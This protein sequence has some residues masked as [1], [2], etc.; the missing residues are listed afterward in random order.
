MK[1]H[2]KHLTEKPSQGIYLPIFVSPT[3]ASSCVDGR[4]TKG[5]KDLLVKSFSRGLGM[6]EFFLFLHEVGNLC[7]RANVKLPPRR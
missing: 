2:L 3:N 7:S 1:L 6:I 4:S 5:L